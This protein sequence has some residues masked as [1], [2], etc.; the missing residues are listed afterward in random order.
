MRTLVVYYSRTGNNRRI[1]S[2]LAEALGADIEELKEEADRSGK[3]G[4][5]M[6]GRDAMR[7]RPARLLPL[8]HN[9][10]NY[11]LVV[12]GGPC[13]AFTMCTPTR[14]YGIEHRHSLRKV[15][16]FATAGSGGSAQ[17]SVGA[18]VEAMGI[19]PLASL[20]L[21]DAEVSGEHSE[22]VARFVGEVGAA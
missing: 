16:F 1:A 6:A 5:M 7:R 3:V 18:M 11:D 13:W 2:E 17:K 9:P 19:E 14:T 22:A 15:A 12:L 21:S 4:Y 10:A 8:S 20:V